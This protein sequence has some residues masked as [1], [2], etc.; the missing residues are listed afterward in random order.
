MSQFLA[1]DVDGSEGALS[2]PESH[3]FDLPVVTCRQWRHQLAAVARR[4]TCTYA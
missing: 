3:M 2:N 1:S 4:G